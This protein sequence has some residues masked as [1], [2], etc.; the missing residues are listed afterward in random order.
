MFL[1][2]NFRILR[3]SL[4]FLRDHFHIITWNFLIIVYSIISLF[5]DS[6]KLSIR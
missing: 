2:D 1:R 3:E 4:V 5:R 6:E